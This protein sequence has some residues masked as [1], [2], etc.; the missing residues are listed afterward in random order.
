MLNDL[1]RFVKRQFVPG[2]FWGTLMQAV[3]L[4]VFLY[5]VICLIFSLDGQDV[6]LYTGTGP[7][8]QRGR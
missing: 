5:I 7:A 4:F 8:Q 3:G 2:S 1:V 6:D